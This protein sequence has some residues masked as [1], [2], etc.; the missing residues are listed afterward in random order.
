MRYRFL[1]LILFVSFLFSCGPKPAVLPIEKERLIPILVDVHI[2]EAAV[3]SLRKQEKDSVIQVYYDQIF[4]IHKISEDDFY[5]SME[6]LKQDAY[7]LEQIYEVVLEEVTKKG[8]TVG[9]N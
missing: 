7:Q 6:V 2:A 3:Q 8:A 5:A 9:K 4:E 1:S